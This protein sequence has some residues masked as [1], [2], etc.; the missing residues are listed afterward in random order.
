MKTG[1][2]DKVRI[3]VTEAEG[4]E[5]RVNDVERE[6]RVEREWRT[7]LEKSTISKT[8]KI[9]QLQ[10]ELEQLKQISE[11]SASSIYF[12][13]AQINFQCLPCE[14]RARKKTRAL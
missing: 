2:E 8:E 5:A 7:S 13:L 11:V 1:V 12:K 9:S 14:F 4:K 10:Q 3:L 6:L